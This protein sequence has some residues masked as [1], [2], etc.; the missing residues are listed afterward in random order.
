MLDDLSVLTL[1]INKDSIESVLHTQSFIL[2]VLEQKDFSVGATGED[3]R[4][5][6][7]ET[8]R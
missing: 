6:G 4:L 5:P 1:K 2:D 8:D 7:M 3:P